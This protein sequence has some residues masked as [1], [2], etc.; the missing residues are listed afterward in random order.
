VLSAPTMPAVAAPLQNAALLSLDNT[1][2][3]VAA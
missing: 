3:N 1:Q 2:A